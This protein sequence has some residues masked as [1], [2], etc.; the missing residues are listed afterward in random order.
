[1]R[2]AAASRSS[3]AV[4][5][6]EETPTHAP[7]F[8]T[9]QRMAKAG[10]SP[11]GGGGGGGG[12]KRQRRGGRGG[13]GGHGGGGSECETEEEDEAT[14]LASVMAGEVPEAAE[15]T[16]YVRNR[17]RRQVRG[18]VYVC[19]KHAWQLDVRGARGCG[20]GKLLPT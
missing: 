16:E 7:Y 14:F 19:V 5:H 12:A 1:M 2:P 17:P 3:A 6:S 4:R 18:Q 15:P 9:L 11:G 20:C 10:K 13:G 8:P